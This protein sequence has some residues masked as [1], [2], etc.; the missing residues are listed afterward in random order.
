MSDRDPYPT[1]VLYRELLRT[2]PYYLGLVL[3]IV[4]GFLV[5]NLFF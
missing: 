4:G 2:L 3:L 1:T 5:Y